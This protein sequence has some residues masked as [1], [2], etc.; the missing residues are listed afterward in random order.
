V[1]EKADGGPLENVVALAQQYLQSVTSTPFS[2]GGLNTQAAEN[3]NN[4]LKVEELEE[5]S[6]HFLSCYCSTEEWSKTISSCNRHG[7]TLAHIS[8]MLGYLSLLRHLVAWGIDLNLTDLQGSTALHYAFLYNKPECAALLIRS[9]ADELTLDELGRSPW[10][11]NPSMVDEVT[12]RLRGVSRIDDSFPVSCYSMD[13]VCET[14]RPEEASS[15]RAKYL[16]VERWLQQMEEEQHSLSSDPGS[17]FRTRPV[18]VSAN[19]GDENSKDIQSNA[20]E[21]ICH[22]RALTFFYYST[23]SDLVTKSPRIAPAHPNQSR[24]V[25]PKVPYGPHD[26]TDLQSIYDLSSSDAWWDETSSTSSLGSVG[27]TPPAV[28]AGPPKPSSSI[29]P[30]P[31]PT[32]SRPRPTSPMEPS[33]TDQM[34]SDLNELMHLFEEASWRPRGEP[35]I[36]S[37]DCPVLAE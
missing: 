20:T 6:I 26:E 16:L 25:V 4:V 3:C 34:R 21:A 14:E 31:V 27:A 5:I 36:G 17:G 19:L 35:I 28:V 7:Q 22:L 30:P 37:P 33:M 24:G 13:N 2:Q 23:D 8:V 32:A 1:Y 29:G 10:A 18:N 9:G 12:S 15:P 11:L